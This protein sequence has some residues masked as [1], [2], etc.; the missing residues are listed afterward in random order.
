MN[1]SL[2][3]L[4]SQ[5]KD[6]IVSAVNF[7]ILC[8]FAIEFLGTIGIYIALKVW[9]SQIWAELWMLIAFGYALKNE[10][11]LTKQIILDEV[12]SNNK[13]E[14]EDEEKHEE[15]LAEDATKS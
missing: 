5:P 8:L 11:N 4:K 3:Y 1:N 2:D 15:A 10:L 7:A 14:K 13:K 6:K 9:T 12:L